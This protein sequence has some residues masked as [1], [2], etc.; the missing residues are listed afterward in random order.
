[1]HREEPSS[2][3]YSQQQR[4]G[5]VHV[6]LVES[7]AETGCGRGGSGARRSREHRGVPARGVLLEQKIPRCNGICL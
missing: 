5:D 2:H 6:G 1:M 3:L 7:L 4:V